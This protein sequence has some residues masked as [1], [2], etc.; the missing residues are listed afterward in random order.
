M[1]RNRVYFHIKNLIRS[2]SVQPNTKNN[3][4]LIDNVTYATDEWTNITPKI[5]SH[6]SANKH[7]QKNH[8]LSIIRQRIVNYFYKSFTTS[9]GN[10]VFSVY[11]NLNPVVTVQQNFDNLLIPESHPSRCKSDCYYVNKQFLL[12]AHTTAH[13]VDLIKSGLDNFLVVGDVYRRDEIDSTHYPVFH[14]IDAVRLLNRDQIFEKHPGLQIFES[15]QLNKSFVKDIDQAKQACHTLESLKLAEYELKKVLSGL[16]LDLFGDK[17]EY[18]WVQQYFPFT[19]PSWELEIFY[20]NQWLEVLG[21]GIIRNEILQKA[22]VHNSIG[23]A[24]GLGLER[25]AM[26]LF[27]IPDIRLFWSN[28]PGF[29]NQFDESNLHILPKYKP[30][31]TYPQCSNDISFWLPDGMEGEDFLVNDFYDLV[32]TIA[33][34]V[35]EQIRLVD[36]FKHPKS[37]KSSL[38]FRIVYRHMEK[39]LTQSEVNELHS[40]IAQE[41]VK[42]FNVNIR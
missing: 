18:R 29:L 20:K 7:L 40:K 19:Q 38:C 8:P 36:Q 30:V 3:K 33:G 13:Q 32:R 14:Q 39:T 24:F 10:P 15:S 23:Y 12:R 26:V 17:I 31:S 35:V 5:L 9:R 21:C 34:D 42:M 2:Y 41:C 28:D 22:G 37:G 25:L 6:I 16:A 11:D 4:I 27:D 1:Q